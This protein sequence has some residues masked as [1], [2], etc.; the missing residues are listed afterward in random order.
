MRFTPKV[1]LGPPGVVFLDISKCRTLQSETALRW[2]LRVLADRLRIRVKIAVAP[3]PGTALGLVR[4]GVVAFDELP[5][6]ALADVWSPFRNGTG[7]ETGVRFLEPIVDI[8]HRLG[9]HRLAEFLAI[10]PATLAS[11]FG[12][13]CVQISQWLKGRPGSE[14]QWPFFVPAERFSERE[15]VDP[16]FGLLDLEPVLFLLKAAVDRLV[17]RLKGRARR[18]QTLCLNLE[19][20][21]RARRS[22]DIRTFT[23]DFASPISSTPSLMKLLTERLTRDLARTPLLHAV[24]GIEITATHLVPAR[25]AQADFFKTDELEAEAFALL[26]SRLHQRLGP[27]ASFCARLEPRYLPEHGWKKR[28]PD[29]GGSLKSAT[30]PLPFPLRPLR[31]FRKPKPMVREGGRLKHAAR[32]WTIDRVGDPERIVGEWWMAP[33][34]RTTE[35]DYMR[36]DTKEGEALWVY[37][38]PGGALFLHGIFD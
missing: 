19:H 16:A 14:L 30:L 24:T 36:V 34:G 9:V 17:I 25:A 20:E 31:L 12:R 27:G 2:R 8:L 33:P 21:N 35:R 7:P 26:L 18:I 1:A 5:I 13:E 6:E 4:F 10:P 23:L 3:D 22:V 28:T 15:D 29:D 37:R 32:E 38:V 11:R